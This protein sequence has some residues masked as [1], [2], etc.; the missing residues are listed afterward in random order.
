MATGSKRATPDQLR[1]DIDRGRS[2][3]K[4]DW[5]DPASAPLG[6]DEEAAGTPLTPDRVDAARQFERRGRRQQQAGLGSAWILVGFIL[7]LFAGIV[8]WF[9]ATA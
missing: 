2:G 4:I 9:L 7:A 8:A 1:R 5:P 3:D 6:T